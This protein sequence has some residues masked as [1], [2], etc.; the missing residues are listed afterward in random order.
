MV[1]VLLLSEVGEFRPHSGMPR[2]CLQCSST[3]TL[4]K[5]TPAYF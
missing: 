5:D 1:L 4:S 3:C 2:Y